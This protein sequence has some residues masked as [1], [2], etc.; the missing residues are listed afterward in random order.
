MSHE[1]HEFWKI[2]TMANNKR[3]KGNN[4]AMDRRQQRRRENRDLMLSTGN[5]IRAEKMAGDC[6]RRKWGGGRAR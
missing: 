2:T 5:D 6:C 4:R 3:T 1:P